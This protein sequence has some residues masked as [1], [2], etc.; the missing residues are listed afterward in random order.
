[1]EDFA[2][3]KRIH[4]AFSTI[5]TLSGDLLEIGGKYKAIVFSKRDIP[6]TRQFAP[7]KER[8]L[9]RSPKQDILTPIWAI[10]SP[11]TAVR[12]FEGGCPGDLEHYDAG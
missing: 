3:N 5:F 2:Y 1:M 8:K 4:K 10:L 11:E 9:P 6:N 7:F 12:F